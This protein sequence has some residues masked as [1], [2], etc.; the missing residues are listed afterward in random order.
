M[1]NI[2]SA[3][4]LVGIITFFIVYLVSITLANFFQAWLA[5]LMGDDTAEQFGFLTLNPL[6]HIDPIG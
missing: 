6:V 3:E 5:R 1:V 4:F 2:K